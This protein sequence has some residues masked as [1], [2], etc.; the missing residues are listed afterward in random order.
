RI[1]GLH[2]QR[3]VAADDGR[4]EL[5][6]VELGDRL[7]VQRRGLRAAARRRFRLLARQLDLGPQVVEDLGLGAIVLRLLEVT[8]RL[9]ERAVDDGPPDALH[10]PADALLA[11]PLA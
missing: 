7:A 11:R 9:V 8:A 5:A 1:V 6:G 2:A 10:G 4:P 3:G